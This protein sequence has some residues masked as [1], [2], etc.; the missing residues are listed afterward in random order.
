MEHL[1]AALMLLSETWSEVHKSTMLLGPS[2]PMSALLLSDMA[3]VRAF[4]ASERASEQKSERRDG[5]PEST[6]TRLSSW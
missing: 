5:L 1:M 4:T 2:P 3:N 6:G